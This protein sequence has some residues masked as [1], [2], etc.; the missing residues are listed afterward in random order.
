[1]SQQWST[2]AVRSALAAAALLVAGAAWAGDPLPSAVVKAL[3]ASS[4]K[5]EVAML[6]EALAT[7]T[8]PALLPW[9]ELYAGE[10]RRLNGERSLARGHFERVA[11]DFPAHRAKNPAVLGMA[12]VDAQDALSG[13]TLAT[14]ELIA[15]DN[16]PDTLNAD[17]YLLLAQA[18]AREGAERDTVDAL[19]QKAQRYA[20]GDKEVSRRIAKAAGEVEVAG[21]TSAPPVPTGPADQRD[22]E[23][24]RAALAAGDFATARQLAVA[25][26]AKYPTSPWVREAAYAV[27]RADAGVRTVANKVVVLLPLTGE[28]A[29]PAAGLKAAIEMANGRAKSPAQLTFVDTAG[30]PEQ[31]V[32]MLE[33]A[34]IESG[35]A[36]AVGP[37]RK[38]EAA[39]CAPAA[40]ALRVPMVTLA[41]SAE[42][43]LAGDRIFH[44]FPSTEAQIEALLREA[45]DNRRL[46]RFAVLHPKTSYGEN[47]ARAFAE[48][49]QKRGGTVVR[50]V[51]YPADTADFRSIV[52]PLGKA[53]GATAVDY[54][55]LFIPDA[56]QRVALALSALAYAE[57][58]IGR[59]RPKYTDTPIVPLGLNAW[60]NDELA[61]RGGQYVEDSLFVDAFDVRAQDPTTLAFVEA[62]GE[63]GAGPPS[64]VEAT[65][66]DTM[67]LVSAAIAAGGADPGAALQ[68]ARLDTS[69]TGITGFETSRDAA[70]TWHLLT[71]D[72]S[73]VVPVGAEP[74][75]PQ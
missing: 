2:H 63:R 67:L 66:Y 15:D 20:Q 45:Q 35:A 46:T 11:G 13:N 41:S 27:R 74:V 53:A 64:V 16:V 17:R 1:M 3:G 4:R 24:I 44:T 72:R 32:A 51:S 73:G 40:Q 30:K 23:A 39:T 52:K 29:Q 59:F 61:R 65:G 58:P 56:Y 48:A 69:L 26:P 43:L 60:N 22:I 28:L 47:A 21:A 7:T 71:V 34:V 68:S 55:A 31:C 75:A 36:I 54:E 9:V 18:R 25:Y 19:L 70:R 10:A 49:V 57:V 38:E 8:D 37:L 33:K 14:L 42:S 5:A 6:E 50:T 62:W 12:V